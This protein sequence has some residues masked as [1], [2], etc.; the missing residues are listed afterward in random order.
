MPRPSN[1]PA[2]GTSSRW[3]DVFLAVATTASINSPSGAGE[4]HILSAV[5]L[6]Q[7]GAWRFRKLAR[8]SAA[9][10]MAAMTKRGAVHVKNWVGAVS[11]LAGA[12]PL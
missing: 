12:H 1:I 4:T 9:A 3:D 2:A 6:G 8:L 5:P 7:T 11:R 10:T